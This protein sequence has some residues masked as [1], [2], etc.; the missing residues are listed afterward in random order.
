MV[1]LTL[2]IAGLDQWTKGW[3][4]DRLGP[5]TKDRAGFISPPPDRPPLEIWEGYLRFS[6]TG[7]SGAIFGMGRSLPESFKRPFFVLMSSLA[8][9]FI[10]LLVRGSHADQ[11]L[12]RLGL[13][14]I[15]AGAL[16]NFIDRIWLEY[17]VDFIDWYGGFRWPTFNVADVAIS[18]GVGLVLL[19]LWLHPDPAPPFRREAENHTGTDEPRA[20]PAP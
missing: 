3:A 12:R 19:D 18:M 4:V 1:S 7:N 17:V 20:T 15:L 5:L 9:L 2:M 16:G 10:L 14:G 6:I 8:V 11:R 13:A